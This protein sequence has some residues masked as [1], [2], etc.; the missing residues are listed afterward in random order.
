VHGGEAKI[1]PMSDDRF[2]ELLEDNGLLN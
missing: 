1:E 2:D